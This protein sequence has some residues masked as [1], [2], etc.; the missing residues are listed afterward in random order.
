MPMEDAKNGRS[1]RGSVNNHNRLNELLKTRPGGAGRADWGSCDPRW[2]GAVIVLVTKLGG[3]VSFSL[4]RD[5]GAFGLT[6]FSNGEKT[7]LWFNGDADLDTELEN[8]V[9]VLESA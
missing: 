7:A 6:I 9:A 8:V 5:G 1:K 3:A 4:S 2:M